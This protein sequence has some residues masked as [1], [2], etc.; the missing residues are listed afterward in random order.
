MLAANFVSFFTVQG[1]F[2]GIIFGLLKS[3]TASG[4]MS[5]T[6]LISVF[7]YL[8][9]HVIVAFYFRTMAV[10]TYHFSKGTYESNLDHYVKEI[11]KREKVIDSAYKITDEAAKM[12]AESSKNKA[13]A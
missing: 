3:D 2:I 12:N 4:L 7:F 6:L 5:Y 10:R 9:A 8:F 1:F 13:A 11:N